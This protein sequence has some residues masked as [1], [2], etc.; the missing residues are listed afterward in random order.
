MTVVQEKQDTYL[1]NIRWD[2]IVNEILYREY[3]I[4]SESTLNK[5][6]GLMLAQQ[7]GSYGRS[8]AALILSFVQTGKFGQGGM[9]GFHLLG[10]KDGSQYA[11]S[12]IL[13]KESGDAL[14]APG[15]SKCSGGVVWGKNT[16]EYAR[17]CVITGFEIKID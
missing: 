10:A 4:R 6:Y 17:R 3:L 11:T 13:E 8:M 7:V 14:C 16:D 15:Y 12:A 9:V 5:K 2:A 1:S